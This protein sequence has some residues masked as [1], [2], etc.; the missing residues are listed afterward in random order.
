MLAVLLALLLARLLLVDG[1]RLQLLAFL[2]PNM[3]MVALWLLSGV[4]GSADSLAA[5]LGLVDVVDAGD[6]LVID[7]E[8]VLI[9]IRAHEESGGGRA[10]VNELPLSHDLVRLL[11]L[12]DFVVAAY[13]LGGP[14]RSETQTLSAV[15]R[16]AVERIG[17]ARRVLR[18]PRQVQVAR[19]LVARLHTAL[20]RVAIHVV[21]LRHVG[22]GES[23]L[24]G[25]DNLKVA[26]VRVGV[27]L[28]GAAEPVRVCRL[29][30]LLQVLLLDLE[31][32]HPL[33]EGLVERLV[34]LSDLFLQLINPLIG[35]VRDQ[36]AQ[37]SSPRAIS[38]SL[39][40]QVD[41]LQA[42]FP[43]LWL[44]LALKMLQFR[45]KLVVVDLFLV[46]DLRVGSLLL[47]SLLSI[48]NLVEDL[49]VGGDLLLPVLDL[50]IAAVGHGQAVA[51]VVY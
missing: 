23:L 35:H 9:V 16:A 7:T 33:I 48:F 47:K 31:L 10:L 49:D 40:A 30:A 15:G 20:R 36:L 37:L 11:D 32:P 21:P 6:L 46:A 38:S 5:K 22:Q 25:L 4:A 29:L 51:V 14:G 13:S 45:L 43:A 28:V 34:V 50:H 27:M 1:F 41:A 17:K 2:G 42:A 26:D 39:L 12:L 18:V 19:I 3:L 44:E 24:L 8:L